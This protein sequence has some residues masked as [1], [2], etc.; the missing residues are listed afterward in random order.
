MDSDNVLML[1]MGPTKASERVQ[2]VLRF[3]TLTCLGCGDMILEGPK[4]AYRT[5]PASLVVNSNLTEEIAIQSTVYVKVMLLSFT[6]NL[7]PVFQA[8]LLLFLSVS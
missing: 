1:Q 3:D 6:Y 4:I 7:Y 2:N 8:R 5:C